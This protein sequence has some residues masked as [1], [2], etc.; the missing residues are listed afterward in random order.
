MDKI[1][2][3]SNRQV[4]VNS[5][6]RTFINVQI[7]GLITYTLIFILT[8]LIAVS[9]DLSRKYDM[10]FSLLAFALSSFITS[11]YT[12]YK[13]RQNGLISGIVYCLPL[14]IIVILIALIF[15]DFVI[16]YSLLITII[17]LVASSAIGGVL[18]VNKRRRR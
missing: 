10:I 6:V 4:T 7:F 11:F 15:A 2:P 9:A 14:N 5:S 12:G 8:S 18:S 16:D 17:A 13:L 3:K 1:K